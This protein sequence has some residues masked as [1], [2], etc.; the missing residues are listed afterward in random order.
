MGDHFA[1]SFQRKTMHIEKIKSSND[2]KLGQVLVVSKY[3][4]LYGN[5][6]LLHL[7]ESVETHFSDDATAEILESYGFSQIN[8]GLYEEML[9]APHRQRQHGRGRHD[10][11]C[12]GSGGLPLAGRMA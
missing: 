7:R 12:Q 3:C 5:A 1:V 9:M 10:H 11:Q 8:D 4:K 2:R 6:A